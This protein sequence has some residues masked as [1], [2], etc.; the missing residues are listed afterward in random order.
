MDFENKHIYVQTHFSTF[1]LYVLQHDTWALWSPGYLNN[2]GEK[3]FF[4]CVLLEKVCIYVFI[5][6][7]M[8]HQSIN[9]N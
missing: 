9:I 3:V 2:V 4:A 5:H 7:C 8:Y 6:V 1:R